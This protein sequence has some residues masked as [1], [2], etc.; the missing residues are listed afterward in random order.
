MDVEING[1]DS[2]K[3]QIE[4]IADLEG[5]VPMVE[6]FTP[7]FMKMYTDFESFDELLE[8]SSWTVESQADFEAIPEDE[9]DTYIDE[10]TEFP[11]WQVMYETGTNQYLERKLGS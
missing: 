10:N 6:I 2:L 9:F 3:E 1:L 8:A 4:E 5:G 11:S 7:E